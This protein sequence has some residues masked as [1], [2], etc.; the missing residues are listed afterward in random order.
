MATCRRN[1]RLLILPESAK[2]VCY[3][4]LMVMIG[5]RQSLTLPS[6]L[7]VGLE[8]GYDFEPSVLHP[9]DLIALMGFAQNNIES[10]IAIP[11]GAAGPALV[12]SVG[13]DDASKTRKQPH[14]GG[15]GCVKRIVLESHG[16]IS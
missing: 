10:G 13:K 12:A 8:D 11:S 7:R 4:H 16:D 6:T 5:L 3:I 14:L 15:V 1:S 9:P 2:V